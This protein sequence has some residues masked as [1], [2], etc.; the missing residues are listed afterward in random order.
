MALAIHEIRRHEADSGITR[1]PRSMVW[2][3]KLPDRRASLFATAFLNDL[4]L[5]V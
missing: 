3:I 1:N 4:L 2:N 5:I